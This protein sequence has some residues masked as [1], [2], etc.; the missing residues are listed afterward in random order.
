MLNTLIKSKPFRYLDLTISAIIPFYF[1]TDLG[2]INKTENK[3]R[4]T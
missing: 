1:S 3:K 4:E 2:A